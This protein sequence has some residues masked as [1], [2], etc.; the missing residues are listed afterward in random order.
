[1]EELSSIST[2]L[3]KDKIMSGEILVQRI[4]AY[5]IPYG[6]YI[7]PDAA[8]EYH[9]AT[10]IADEFDEFD[11]TEITAQLQGYADG[12]IVGEYAA[13]VNDMRK[14]ERTVGYL[15][16]T[17][18]KDGKIVIDMSFCKPDDFL[19]F[20]ALFGKIL[21]C[22]SMYGL[23]KHGVRRFKQDMLFTHLIDGEDTFY[24]MPYTLMQTYQYFTE[25][26]LR[27]FKGHEIDDTCK[28][29]IENQ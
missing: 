17:L 15:V 13:Y 23:S 21:A 16:A 5:V 19:M 22:V 11:T 27:Y 1:M 3:F 6:K 9:N 14:H 10:L 12:H 28:F 7:L 2:H 25:R 18:N 24:F 20:K 26:T 29:L 8:I 4:K